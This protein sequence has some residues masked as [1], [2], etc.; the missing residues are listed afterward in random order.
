MQRGKRRDVEGEILSVGPRG[1]FGSGS[2][3]NQ[4]YLISECRMQSRQSG[5]RERRQEGTEEQQYHINPQLMFDNSAKTQLFTWNLATGP[6]G[7]LI[8]PLP[9]DKPHLII[10]YLNTV[11]LKCR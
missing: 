2:S 7:S 9:P 10:A 8:R 11:W 3:A 4:V 6:P 5:A 1:E